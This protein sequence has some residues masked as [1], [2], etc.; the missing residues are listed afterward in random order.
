MTNE[1]DIQIKI[2]LQLQG[3]AYEIYTELEH[4]QQFLVDTITLSEL[5]RALNT[6]KNAHDIQIKFIEKDKE[7]GGR[8]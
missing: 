8:L 1:A 5:A 6:E 2:T 4:I 3:T 7:T